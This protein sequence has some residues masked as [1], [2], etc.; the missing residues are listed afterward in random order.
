MRSERNGKLSVG[1]NV[2][3]RS[4]SCGC[5][6]MQKKKYEISLFAFLVDFSI[7]CVLAWVK[8]T[9]ASPSFAISLSL[10]LPWQ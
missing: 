5:F 9:D 2:M 4:R 3:N 7:A 1:E 10:T 6:I 8:E